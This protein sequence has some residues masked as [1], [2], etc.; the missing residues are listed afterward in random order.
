[1]DGK[2]K[3]Y[4][5]HICGEKKSEHGA[6]SASDDQDSQVD[7]D[8]TEPARD[9]SIY[10]DEFSDEEIHVENTTI[11]ESKAL[12]AKGPVASRFYQDP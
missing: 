12:L 1:M 5:M 3:R 4:Q 7:N 11:L 6:P 9:R 10:P 8:L 2:N